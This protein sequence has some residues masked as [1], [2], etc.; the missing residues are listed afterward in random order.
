MID[1]RCLFEFSQKKQRFLFHVYSGEFISSQDLVHWIST[2]D[3]SE[4][5]QTE[6]EKKHK[7]P[8]RVSQRLFSIKCF[9]GFSWSVTTIPSFIP[10]LTITLVSV[11]VALFNHLIRVLSSLRILI[12][13]YGFE[14]LV[15]VWLVSLLLTFVVA[16]VFGCVPTP[17]LVVPPSMSVYISFVYIYL[18]VSIA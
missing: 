6:R 2:S 16:C 5:R 1:F 4:G 12:V 8:L 7:E 15:R 17:I 14:L 9:E 13:V 3:T 11:S 18:Y 10:R